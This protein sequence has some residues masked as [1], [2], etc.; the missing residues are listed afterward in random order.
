M[1]VSV[2]FRN[3]T[4]PGWLRQIPARLAKLIWQIASPKWGF[5]DATFDRS[6]AAFDNPDHISIVIHNYRWRLS[7]A[8]VKSVRYQHRRQ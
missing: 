3:R 1:V 8:N 7:L 6:A 5:D 4:R 2:L